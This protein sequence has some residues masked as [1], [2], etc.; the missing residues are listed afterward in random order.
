MIMNKTYYAIA[1]FVSQNN[2]FIKAS[3]QTINAGKIENSL[4]F[5]FQS[6]NPSEAISQLK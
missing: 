6:F 2:K 5:Y 3:Q 4:P 1:R